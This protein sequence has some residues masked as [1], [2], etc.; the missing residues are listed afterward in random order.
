MAFQSMTGIAERRGRGATSA[1]HWEARSVNS[2][3][4]ELRV[5]L[6]E[7]CELL[8]APVRRIFGAAFSRGSITVTL[9][10]ATEAGAG[11]LQVDGARVDTVLAAAR[12][13]A[14]RAEF[15]GMVLSAFTALDLMRF[16]DAQGTKAGDTASPECVEATLLDV[17]PLAQDLARARIEE[18]RALHRVLEER[19][20]RIEA[21]LAAARDAETARSGLREAAVRQKVEVVLA[22]GVA[23][24]EGRLAQELALIAI[25]AD[26]R[27]ELD[28]LA[29]HVTMARGLL[30]SDGP[31][32]RKFDFLT[33]ELV[34]E[35][36]TICSKSGSIDLTAI[37]LEL[38]A[39][40]DQVREQ[41][42]NVE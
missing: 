30:S 34:R 9:R 12:Q 29:S 40:I 4:L 14:E 33:Q 19:V 15:H 27:E 1:W 42:Q 16:C 32:G 23:V 17:A 35:V 7:G 41:I 8:E 26:V 18:G 28:R 3:G 38:K 22:S 25:R 5:R 31:A 20:D 6:P 24:D 13:I 36:N 21:L 39:V 37:G 10:R 11:A 2:R